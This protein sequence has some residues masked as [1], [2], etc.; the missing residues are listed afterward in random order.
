MRLQGLLFALCLA[1][2]AASAEEAASRRP[3]TH[4]DVWLM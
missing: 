3:I 2:G 1:A 4:G